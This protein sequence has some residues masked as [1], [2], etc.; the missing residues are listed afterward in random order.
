MTEDI[1]N[2]LMQSFPSRSLARY[3]FDDPHLN[4][5]RHELKSNLQFAVIDD[6][7]I[8]I[9]C[10]VHFIS[11]SFGFILRLDIFFLLNNQIPRVM[12]LDNRI[13]KMKRNHHDQSFSCW[14]HVSARE[15]IFTLSGPSRQPA[16]QETWNCFIS[17]FARPGCNALSTITT[18]DCVQLFSRN[19][20][21]SA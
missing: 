9:W 2:N 15:T 13:I 6:Y 20:F 8:D 11:L 1:R 4:V 18:S 3:W 10:R 5:H 17:H 16:E 19:Q 7:I 12:A 21:A 14:I